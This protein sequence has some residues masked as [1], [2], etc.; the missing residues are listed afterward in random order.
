MQVP[1]RLD[2]IVIGKDVLEL[3]SSA[4]YVDPLTIFREYVQ[5]A[6]DAIDE[7]HAAGLY[8]KRETG[9]VGIEI[10]AAK[11]KVTIRDNGIGLPWKDF[12]RRMTALGA[13]AKRGGTARGFRG[14]GRLAGLGYAQRLTFRSRAQ[15]DDLVSELSWDCR[16]LRSALRSSESDAGVEELIRRAVTLSRVSAEGYPSRF[17]EVELDG[18]VRL[19]S[20]SLM[21]PNAIAEYLAQVAP[22]P[23]APDFAFAPQIRDALEPA[24][25]LDTLELRI[26]G[27]DGPIY[28]PHRRGFG[29]EKRKGRFEG[30]EIFTIPDVDGVPAAVGWLLHHEYDGAVPIGTGFKG[31]RLRVGNV[32]I[33]AHA[34]LEELF[35][36][37]RFNSWS[38]GEVHVLDR[39]IVPNA[40]RDDFEQNAHYSNLLNQLAP[41]ARA[42][43]KRCRTSSKR[44]QRMRDFQLQEQSVN[45]RLQILRQGGIGREARKLQAAQID[46]ALQKMERLANAPDLEADQTKL[47][48]RVGKLRE[49]VQA[50]A[51]AS[52]I[53]PL[54]LLAP[55]KRAMYGQMFDLIYDCSSNR[56]A[57]KALV[58]RILE[59][60]VVG[61]GSNGILTEKPKKQRRKKRDSASA[62]KPR[63]SSR[64]KV[65]SR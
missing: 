65:R 8:G 26:S 58:D 13:S 4:M 15:D 33:G 16:L 17:F 56:V 32:Q 7:A 38:I 30:L 60:I 48:S 10:D 41:I 2:R 61:K 53:S 50:V 46:S 31:V 64:R 19:R 63:R 9:R 59:K 42:V 57:A 21:S 45:E 5:N 14:V 18:V 24:V 12:C 20:D 3:V 37:P 52:P 51:S 23:F 49:R 40:R 28:R 22:L 29:D 43:S 47:H 44:R 55:H 62:R 36:E 25:K 11:R 34:L 39:R 6:A 1:V 27:L 35:T 54:E